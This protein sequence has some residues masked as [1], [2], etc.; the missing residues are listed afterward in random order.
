MTDV[1]RE[2]VKNL[3]TARLLSQKEIGNNVVT[4]NSRV[5]LKELNN[6]REAEITITYPQDAEPHERKV[7]ILSEVGVALLGRQENDVVSWT[8]PKG[9][10]VFEVKKI[11]YQPEAAGHYYL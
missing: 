9:V 3:K 4:M 7:S 5:K 2:L 8:T 6:S 1:A 10:G 11:V